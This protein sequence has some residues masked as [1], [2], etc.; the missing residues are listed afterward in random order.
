MADYTTSAADELDEIRRNARTAQTMREGVPGSQAGAA[1]TQQRLSNAA[2]AKTIRELRGELGFREPVREAGPVPPRN[3]PLGTP[4]GPSPAA[5]AI[6]VGGD[7]TA[8]QGI[9]PNVPRPGGSPEAV[10]YRQQVAADIGPPKPPASVL[11]AAQRAQ[12]PA[13]AP[14]AAPGATAPAAAPAARPGGAVGGGVRALGIAGA[15]LGALYEGAQVKKVAD[16]PNMTSTDVATQAAEGTARFAGGA[17]GAIAGAKGGAALGAMTGPAAPVA[18]PALATIGGIAG[19]VVGAVGT[20]KII[21]KG[22]E[23]VNALRGSIGLD[24]LPTDSPASRAVPQWQA[25]RQPKIAAP[26]TAQAAQPTAAQPQPEQ[27]ANTQGTPVAPRSSG[28][29]SSIGQVASQAAQP[30][31][32]RDASADMI[33]G[34]THYI[35]TQGGRSVVVPYGP[36]GMAEAVPLEVFRAGRVNDYRNAQVQAELDAYTDPRVRQQEM[37]NRGALE[38][39]G[40][41]NEGAVAAAGVR[42]DKPPLDD[43]ITDP[44][45]KVTGKKVYRPKEGGGYS[46]EVEPVQPTPTAKPKTAAA[47]HAYAKE[48]VAKGWATPDTVNSTLKG[49]GYPALTFSNK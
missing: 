44:T 10:A 27:K 16:D 36:G 19:G 31:P 14:V 33:I 24:P 37:A 23:A 9:N 18:V 32:K 34:E 41:A 4:G 30:A 21:E 15:G 38:R 42:N 46:V 22:R 17:A 45:G 49:W 3:V 48:A 20:D 13:A 47:A 1:D 26:G 8:R 43:V 29:P 40:L 11:E 2:P 6:Y 25:D 28:A 12:A 7:G 35:H 5:G 39:Q